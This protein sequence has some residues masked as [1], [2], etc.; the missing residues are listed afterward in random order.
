MARCRSPRACQRTGTRHPARD[1]V[2]DAAIRAKSGLLGA[3]IGK[4]SLGWLVGWAEK[5][6]SVTVF[7]AMNMDCKKPS[8]VAARMTVTQPMPRADIV[9]I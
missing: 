6:G 3:E 9:A 4:P 5:G 1:K 2:G 8:H 7:Y